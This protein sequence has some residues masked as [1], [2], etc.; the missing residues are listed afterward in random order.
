MPKG[1]GPPVLIGHHFS[2]TG[3][4]S[5]IRHAQKQLGLRGIYT[6][7][8][9]TNKQRH[10]NGQPMFDELPKPRI[11]DIR[12]L[13]GHGL[14]RQV[15]NRFIGRDALLFTIVRD[16]FERFASV[17]KHRLRTLPE[18]RWPT[19]R[20]LFEEQRRS[21][22]AS[23]IKRRFCAPI[24]DPLDFTHVWSGLARFDMVLAT[25]HLDDQNEHLFAHIGLSGTRERARVYPET[26]EL[27]DVTREEVYERDAVDLQIHRRAV[28]AWERRGVLTAF[29]RNTP[30]Y[31]ERSPTS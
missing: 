25:E 7:G 20:A 21:P 29:R 31:V 10:A 18:E 13:T 4:T 1:D 8:W 16:P 3:G 15:V 11:D 14:T 5:I 27:G 24:R 23:E 30:V 28:Q 6:Y 26:P 2:K 22:F 9:A 17:Y 12:V 19:P